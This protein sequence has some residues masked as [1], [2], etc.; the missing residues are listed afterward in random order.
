[1]PLTG[2]AEDTG[3]RTLLFAALG[4]AALLLSLFFRGKA[5]S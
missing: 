5:R 2:A 3:S 1:M 4:M